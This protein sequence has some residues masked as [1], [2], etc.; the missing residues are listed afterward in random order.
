MGPHASRWAR[1]Q[2]RSG[3]DFFL[4]VTELERRIYLWAFPGSITPA[5]LKFQLTKYVPTLNC[6]PSSLSIWIVTTLQPVFF[7]CWW[8]LKILTASSR[9]LWMDT[10]MKAGVH[11]PYRSVYLH[12][13]VFKLN[14]AGLPP[15]TNCV[16]LDFSRSNWVLTAVCTVLNLFWTSV[17]RSADAA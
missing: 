3:V 6:W 9:R 5:T 15:G 16:Q 4:R 17:H 10:E 13:T 14:T 2:W 8:E 7:G 1:L 12:S 11:S